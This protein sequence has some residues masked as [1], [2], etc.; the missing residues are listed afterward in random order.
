MDIIDNTEKLGISQ[1]KIS[2]LY[3][4]ILRGL[5][6]R[7]LE[8]EQRRYKDRGGPKKKPRT[9][10]YLFI[11]GRSQ[12]GILFEELYKAIPSSRATY[13]SPMSLVLICLEKAD[14]HNMQSSSSHLAFSAAR[15]TKSS[16]VRAGEDS[17]R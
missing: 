8:R 10:K 5:P 7:R 13:G 2:I 3:S 14:L 17:R 4:G 1:G 15:S 9:R 16:S 12:L 11:K 6:E